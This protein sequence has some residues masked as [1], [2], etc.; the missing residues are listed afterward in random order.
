A[1][2]LSKRFGAPSTTGRFASLDGLR[3]YLAF[4]VFIYHSSIWYYFVRSGK[5]DVPPSRV[6]RNLGQA[7]V[8][9]FFMI[10]GFLF[11][12]KLLRGRSEL[13]DW[14]KLYVSRFLRLVPLY[15]LAIALMVLT[16]CIIT[17]F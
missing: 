15:I 3:G 4:G 17:S 16:V 12:S 5:W 9:L 13:I 2:I 10:T 6:Y 14:R 1:W 8:M 7:S 11:C